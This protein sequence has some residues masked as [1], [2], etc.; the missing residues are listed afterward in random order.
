MAKIVLLPGLLGQVHVGSIKQTPSVGVLG[1]GPEPLSL[2]A[3]PGPIGFEGLPTARNDPCEQSDGNRASS[4]EGEL[5]ALPSLVKLTGAGWTGYDGLVVQMPPEIR[6]ETVG[7]FVPAA[8][9]LLQALHHDP[10]Q[11]ALHSRNLLLQS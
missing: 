6:R 2:F 9:L 7:G 11:V 5:V 1:V 10:V 8:A 3:D 4:N